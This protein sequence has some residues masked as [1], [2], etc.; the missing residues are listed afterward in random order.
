VFFPTCF[1]AAPDSV[2]TQMERD[3]IEKDP[4]NQ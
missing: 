2:K 3:A 1:D 4:G